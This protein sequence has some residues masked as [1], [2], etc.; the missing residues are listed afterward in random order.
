MRVNGFIT[1]Y[2]CTQKVNL[3]RQ[4]YREVKLCTR[5]IDSKLIIHDLLS[6]LNH[7]VSIYK[8]SNNEFQYMMKTYFFLIPVKA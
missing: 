1:E 5:I 4:I 7:F 8:V 6:Y 2:R 3:M